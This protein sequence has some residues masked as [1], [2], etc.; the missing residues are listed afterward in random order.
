MTINDKLSEI[1]SHLVSSQKETQKTISDLQKKF[2]EYNILTQRPNFYDDNNASKNTIEEKQHMKY[3]TSFLQ[4]LEHGKNIETTAIQNEFEKKY[5]SEGVCGI[6]DDFSLNSCK[7]GGYLISYILHKK[8]L[9]ISEEENIFR[10]LVSYDLVSGGRHEYIQAMNGISDASWVEESAN[11][12]PT[13]TP[14]LKKL[15]I[16]LNEMYAEPE[17]SVRLIEDSEINIENWLS[18][19]IADAFSRLEVNAILYGDGISKPR[20]ITED[21]N[22]EV[23][24]TKTAKIIEYEDISKLFDSLDIGY[25]NGASFVMSQRAQGIISELKD[26]LGRPLWQQSIVEKIPSTLFGIPVYISNHLDDGTASGDIP[27]I[28]GDFKQGYKLIETIPTMK[29]DDLTKKQSILF[30]TRK[31]VGGSVLNSNAL[32]ILKVK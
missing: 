10:K 30:Y 1:L 21:S 31:R 22:V 17:V 18:Y 2:E 24:A 4:Y 28:L 6:N 5:L 26:S 14:T 12:V 3:H 7:N 13:S 16:F 9:R 29:R 32:K 11:R 25:R 15:T 23:I 19:E 27:I 20:G 8:I